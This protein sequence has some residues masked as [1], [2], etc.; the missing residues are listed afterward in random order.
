MSRI[1]GKTGQAYDVTMDE[2]HA[3]P[4]LN[5]ARAGARPT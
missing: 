5:V 2:W 1:Q 3:A 4:S